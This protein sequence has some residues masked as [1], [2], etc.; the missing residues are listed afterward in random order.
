MALNNIIGA[1][2]MLNGINYYKKVKNYNV[3]MMNIN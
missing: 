1:L 3:I 2:K